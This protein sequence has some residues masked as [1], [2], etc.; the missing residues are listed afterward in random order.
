[1]NK[2][3]YLIKCTAAMLLFLTSCDSEE[4]VLKDETQMEVPQEILN[5]TYNGKTYKN[6]PTAYNEDGDFIFFDENLAK[7]YAQ[8]LKGSRD[9]SIVAKDPHTVILYKD[10]STAC[11]LEGINLITQI[12]SYEICSTMFLTRKGY[13]NLGFLTLYDDRDFK[14]RSYDF[15]LND[16]VKTL[17][18]EDLKKSPWKFNDKCSSLILTNNLPN[19]P[20]KK[21]VLGS[22]EYACTDIDVVFIGYDDRKFT[23]RTI[24]CIAP[25][26][27][28]MKYASLP[29][30]NDK[31][32]S[33]KLFFAQKGQYHASF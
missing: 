4:T 17:Q 8:E 18:V 30:F 9:L 2:S 13:E 21:I 24:T 10:L 23:D 26:A 6:V 27:Q 31:M 22:Y 19:D 11:K 15:A 33:F 7:V 1:M 25:T 16:S 28:V 12:P 20:S 3:V 5:V 14:D 29:G 32:S